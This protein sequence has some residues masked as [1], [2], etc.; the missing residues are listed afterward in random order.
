VD[1]SYH[2]VIA[3]DDGDD[4]LIIQEA[5]RNF[6]AGQIR[7]SPVYNGEELQALLEKA[8]H[9]PNLI[10]L[11]INMP[12][13]NGL[14]ALEKIKAHPDHRSIPVYV[15]STLRTPE[16]YNTAMKLGAAN[17]Y[18]KPNLIEE[19]KDVMKEIFGQAI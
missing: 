4:Q 11:D 1:K 17:F 14:E 2:I 10:L 12:K 8:D 13:V 18:T 19:Y 15:F 5:I 3:D 16:R 6:N 9:S 7:I